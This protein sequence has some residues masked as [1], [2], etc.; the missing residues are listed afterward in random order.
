MPWK[1]SC[2]VCERKRFVDRLERGERMTDL[3]RE[4]GISRKTG[5]KIVARYKAKKERGLLDESRAPHRIP[6]RTAREIEER[7]LELRRE[8]PTWGPLKLLQWLE[9]NERGPRWPSK[10]TIGEIVKRAGLCRPRRVRRTVP[11]HWSGLI[12]P[13]KPNELW[14]IDFKG[15]FRLGNK[16]YCYPL[17]ITDAYSRFLIT[18]EAMEKIDGDE[19]WREME[20]AFSTYGMPSAIRSD[21]GS[22][23]ASRGIL[24]LSRL[25][26]RW[27]S[28]GIRHERI[29]PGKPQ[30]NGRHERM[31]RTLKY[32]TTRPAAHSLLAQQERFDRFQH[33]YNEERPHQALGGATPRKM[34]RP[35]S[36][37]SYKGFAPP[38]YPLHDDVRIVASSGHILF[39]TKRL[40][41]S[42]ALAG[43]PVGL[44][45]LQDDRFLISFATID[46]ATWDLENNTL[47]DSDTSEV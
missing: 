39:K 42:S 32:E 21:N 18:C 30:Q 38:E 44:R 37:S 34:Y 16:N 26:A 29:E 36:V 47:V 20:E 7:I 24:A 8:R 19:V 33:I 35:K 4:F 45:E 5:Y 14:C 11:T 28:L 25:S 46:L 3:C 41:L 9:T 27:L 23:F 31:H 2:L 17:T 12:T 10:T 40:F 43:L 6:H 1:E 22:P 13:T 15:H